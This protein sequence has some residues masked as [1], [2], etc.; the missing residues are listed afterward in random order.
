MALKFKGDKLSKK[1]IEDIVKRFEIARTSFANGE[2]RE[3]MEFV[4]ETSIDL[5]KLYPPETPN[6]TR[7]FKLKQG[8]IG[9][10]IGGGKFVQGVIRN[11]VTYAPLVMVRG[12][13]AAIH[14]GRW[15]TIDEIVE[16]VGGD[17]FNVAA[18]NISIFM[19]ED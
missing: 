10:V 7:T 2:L 18:E 9:E 15:N 12:E 1:Q 8:W 17:P 6:Y 5:A 13:Q 19:G 11:P 4:V 3:A 14:A 16:N